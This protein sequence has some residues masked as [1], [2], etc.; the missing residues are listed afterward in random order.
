VNFFEDGR[1]HPRSFEASIEFEDKEEMQ[2][3]QDAWKSRRG[4][5]DDAR[6]QGRAGVDG[7][8]WI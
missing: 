5:E 7:V 6:H 4:G 8:V 3:P 1:C 2:S